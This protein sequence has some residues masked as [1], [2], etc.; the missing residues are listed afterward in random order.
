MSKIEYRKVTPEEKL[1]VDRLQGIVFNFMPNEKEIR[2][3]IEK[4]E[5]KSD[6]T[7]G[8]V[9]ENGRVIAGME[10][11]PFTMWFDG[12]KVKM[13]GI[14]GVAS[15]PE[16]RRQGNIRK[17]F[18]KIYVDIYEQGV[19]F[20]HLYPFSHDYYRKFG[21]EQIG[22]ATKYTL[23]LSS[24]R[25]F[26]NKGSA[27]EFINGDNVKDKLKEVYENYASR[28][29]IMLSRD[30]NKWNDVFNV[31]LFSHERLYYWKDAENNIKAWVKFKKNNNIMEIYDIAWTEHE[32]M[33]GILQFMGMFE[34]AAEK[35]S[36]RA[37]PEFIA[38]IYWNNLYEIGIENQWLGMNR[39]V[40]V[41]RALELINKPD[42]EGKFVI[43]VIDDFA[44]WNN[45]TYTVEYGGGDC[46]VKISNEIE[47]GADIETSER[48]LVQMV[49]GVYELEQIAYRDDVKINGDMQKLKRAFHK[50]PLL[51][52]DYF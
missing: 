2:E 28:H 34:G 9:D 21:Y 8:A 37:S 29:N 45:N 43:K 32:S 41:K 31:S 50:K 20:S 4:G 47:I 10:A 30:E 7:Y 15:M 13:C 6:N 14:G 25:K 49:L 38:E 44:E 16:S 42:G 27:H 33:L 48:A 39:I 36:F 35:L 17:I 12:K 18:E 52:A 5:Y 1:H 19:V 11:I 22:G 51:I 46:S 24:A 23:P 26:K 40:N 3:K